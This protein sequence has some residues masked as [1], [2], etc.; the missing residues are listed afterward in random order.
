MM[1]NSPMVSYVE[2]SPN[3]SG[4]R[5]EPISRITPHCYV[6]QVTVE[7][8]GKSFIKPSKQKSANYGIGTDGRVG[9]Y[10]D[11]GS[12]SWCSSSRYND[13]RAVTI[14]CASDSKSPY[15][16][17]TVVYNTLVSLCVDICR[18]NGKTRLIWRK[19][20][21]NTDSYNPA[22]DEMVL[23]VHRWYSNKSCPGEWMFSRMDDLANTVT[24]QLKD[25]GRVV[26]YLVRI[27]DSNTIIRAGAGSNTRIVRRYIDPGVYT[28][29][30]EKTGRG[31][32]MWCKLKSG[33]GWVPIESTEFVRNV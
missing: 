27:S 9:M 2:L 29:V 30:Q 24:S 26:P 20:R 32:L 21:E 3:N 16:F 22:P 1:S 15:T 13:Q 25:T 18:R 6:G 5:T 31:S 17:N 28:I 14:E 23:S 11:E 10:V 8:M 7:R 4:P 12:R 19:T 33:I